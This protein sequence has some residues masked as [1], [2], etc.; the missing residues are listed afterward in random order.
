M[1]GNAK[2]NFQE[3][4]HKPTNLRTVGQFLDPRFSNFILYVANLNSA[5]VHSTTKTLADDTKLIKGIESEN[6]HNQLQV[7]LIEVG[8]WSNQNNMSLNEDKFEVLQYT[9]NKTSLLKQLP[10]VSD[11]NTYYTPDGLIIEPKECVRDLGIQLSN[12]L[13]WETQISKMTTDARRISA[14]VLRAFKTR[15]KKN[16]AN[17]LQDH[18]AQQTRVLLPPLGLPK[19]I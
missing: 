1:G 18:R 3:T 15:E 17:S 2:S 6:S 14:W 5:T 13:T 7:D 16:N 9:L 4:D 12:T 11:L 8:R 19:D 10:F